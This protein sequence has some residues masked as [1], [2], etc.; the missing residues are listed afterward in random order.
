MQR[1]VT[2]MVAASLVFAA[3]GG[4]D[5]DATDASTDDALE[6]PADDTDQAAGDTANDAGADA[7]APDDA[8]AAEEAGDGALA[9]EAAADEESI[10]PDERDIT[11]VA[12]TDAMPPE[13][14]DEMAAFLQLVEPLVGSVDWAAAT[15]ADFDA[16]ADEFG[17]VA[18]EFDEISAASG[19]D[20]IAVDGVSDF[21]LLIQFAADTAPNTVGFFEFLLDFAPAEGQGPNVTTAPSG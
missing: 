9:D 13:C 3:C 10:D 14:R 4:G 6:A 1:G 5:D 12:S 19:C 2:M 8:P 7:P 16:I 20:V 15:G 21:D 17:I 18:D 11:M